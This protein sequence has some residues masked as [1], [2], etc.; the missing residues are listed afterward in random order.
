MARYFKEYFD[1]LCKTGF[2][3]EQAL[4]LTIGYQNNLLVQTRD[5]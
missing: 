5:T 2:T 1:N 4:Q 3:E